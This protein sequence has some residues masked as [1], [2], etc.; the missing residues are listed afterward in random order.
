MNLRSCWFWLL[1]LLQI[2]G[3]ATLFAQPLITDFSPT[4]GTT[5]DVIMLTGS[6]FSVNPSG[7]S[8]HFWNGVSATIKF[9]SSD[10]LMTVTVPSGASTGPLSIQ[11]GTGNPTYTTGDFL[12]VGSG[13]YISDVSP[14]YGSV[15]DLVTISGV[16][17][18]NLVAVTFNGISSPGSPNSAG[19]Q[20]TTRVPSGATSGYI[21]VSTS[22][23][24][25]NSPAAFTVLGPGPFISD[26]S[27]YVGNPRTTVFIDGVHFTG[28]TNAT[29]NGTPGVNFAVQS[30]T[31]IRVD[32]PTNVSSGRVSVNAPLGSWTTSSNFFVPP[33]VSTFAPVGGR[34]GTNVLITGVNFLDATAVSF[35]G[36]A[37]AG[38]TV[39]SNSGIIA[40]VPAG[41]TTG[42]IRVIAPAGSAFSTGNFALQP[43]LSGFSP[44]FGPA[45]TS[46]TLTG[47]NL[48]A[49][50]PVVRFNGVASTS[51]TGISFGQVTATVPT[52]ATTGPI[53]ITTSDGSYTN[54]NTFYLPAGITSFAPTNSAPGSSITVQGRNFLGATAVS[55]NGTPA[56]SFQVTN[57]STLRAIVPSGL[58]T[59]PLLV[60]TPAGVAQS[61]GRFYGAPGITS[62]APTHGLPNTSV[63]LTGSNF[64][65]ATVVSFGGVGASFSVNNNGQ[66]TAFV[67]NGAQSGPITVVA[68]AGTN[69]SASNFILDYTS[70]LTVGVTA[71]PNPVTLGS[72]LVFTVSIFNNGPYPAQNLSVTNVLPS[73]V[74]LQS[75]VAPAGWILATNG[76]TLIG[77]ITNL[78]NSGAAALFVTV[79]PQS[80]G[81][82]VDNVSIGSAFPDPNPFDNTSSVTVTVNPLAL[83]SISLLTNQVEV[84]WPVAL[85]NYILQYKNLPTTNAFWSN[86]TTTS[87][88]SGNLRMV[89]ETNN[90]ASK[91]YR[92][93]Q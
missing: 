3:G 55:F 57:N 74:A 19:T 47:A 79:V 91:Y 89:I 34:T 61:T 80:I 53:S 37:A 11:Q 66:I 88:I 9:I 38:Y 63:T 42:I 85:S 31:L 20:I 22:Y 48:N 62:F 49:G 10:T 14:A 46:V 71:A 8:V 27:P 25:S 93:R 59:G 60:S 68:P 82:I 18:T 86:V 7:I 26:F 92:L 90:M 30:D 13:P 51:V 12:V 54:A 23:G 29:F 17:L 1:A 35:N 83:L 76:N 67:P 75:V 21:T 44:S 72:N 58:T 5:G 43:T 73:T 28:A 39:L 33:T 4:A 87:I 77:S 81:S 36:L 78:V 41:A 52:G 6:G 64:F 40:T 32:T 15:N 2:G 16:H 69:S 45:G 56:T 24:T 50:T 65:G 70:D 84:S